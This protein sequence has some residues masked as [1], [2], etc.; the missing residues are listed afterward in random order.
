MGAK[1]VWLK[2]EAKRLGGKRLGGKRLWAKRLF[3]L[4]DAL[5]LGCF[6]FTD[7]PE[8]ADSFAL[9]NTPTRRSENLEV[10]LL[11]LILES[12]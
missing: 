7:I 3:T 9:A 6:D 2:I 11:A 12:M 1:R 4:G 5:T 8:I 10:L